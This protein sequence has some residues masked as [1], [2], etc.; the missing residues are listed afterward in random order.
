[1]RNL[2]VFRILDN[3]PA[4]HY[5]S[6]LCLRR[7]SASF[8]LSNLLMIMKKLVLALLFLGIFSG[9][10]AGQPTQTIRGVVRDR[11]SEVP[12]RSV[13]VAVSGA[14]SSLN[15]STDSLGRFAIPGVPVG[16]Y[17][18]QATLMGYQ[19]AISKEIL[20]TSARETF[21]EIWMTESAEALDAIVVT[22]QIDKAEPLNYMALASARVLSVEEASRYAGGFDDP[23][24]LASSFAGVTG[25]MGNNGIVVRGNSP[26]YFQWKMEDVEIPNP[27]HFADVTAFGGGGLTALSSHVLGNSDFF[28]GAFPA[29]YGNALSGVF[30]VNMRRGN[31]RKM[32]NTFQIGPLGIDLASEGPFKKDGDA[33]YIFNYRYSTLALL[34]PLM[35]EDADGTQ[36][37]DLSFKLNFPTRKAGT[38]SLWGIGL[39]DRSGQT[40]ETDP[41]DWVYLQDMEDQDVK[42][43]MGAAG[44][45]H[46]IAAGKGAYLKTTLAATV[47]GLDMHTERMDAAAELKPQNVI[48][49]T[50]W[51]FVFTSALNKKFNSW[52]TNRTGVRITGL[53]YDM[54][55]EEAYDGQSIRTVADQSGF[56]TLLQAYSSSSLQLS[57]AWTFNVGVN[58]QWLTLNDS[59]AIEP[60]AGL[61]WTFRPGQS[62]G[63]SYGMHS[64][65]EMLN[66]Y[67]SGPAGQ[68]INKDIDFT[69]AHHIVLSYDYTIGRDYHLKIEPYYQLLYDVPILPGTSFSLINLQSDWFIT[70]RLENSGKG[71]NYGVDL[72]FEKYVSRGFYYMFTASVFES[73]YRAGDGVWHSTRFNRNYAVNLLAGKE[74]MTGRRDQNTFGANFR[75]TYQGGDRYSPVDDAASTAAGDVVYDDTKAFSEQLGPAFLCHFTVNYRINRAKT[76]HEFALKVL[77]ATNYKD[78]YGHRYNFRTHSAEPEREA[79]MIPNISYK[80]QF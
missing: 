8:A 35:P 70:D 40:A 54:L 23:A 71:M 15:A 39:V 46:K 3:L 30:D 36:Y 9:F 43:Y 76:S 21:V 34:S 41:A 58:A 32:E 45:S 49:N 5:K 66:Y 80:I 11:S 4:N 48:K 47:G 63:V 22:P 31:N 13:S 50:N 44:L 1:M 57:D 59:Y 24:R 20:V 67:F 68:Q 27:N 62:I 78:Y 16:R 74:W 7:W 75:I 25:S 29:E 61:R 72:T 26:V 14:P 19:P 56:S 17:D 79:I 52:H 38:F 64:R 33:S 69:R 65:M 12:L 55:L 10:A 6:V 51:N 28:T 60:R 73:K 77:N 42:Q 37:Q 18:I 2:F 53:Q